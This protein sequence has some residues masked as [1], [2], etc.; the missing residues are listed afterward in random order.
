MNKQE[1]LDNLYKGLKELDDEDML[2]IKDQNKSYEEKRKLL[3]KNG[4]AGIRQKYVLKIAELESEKDGETYNKLTMELI[5]HAVKHNKLV[6]GCDKP[7]TNLLYINDSGGGE[8]SH[9]EM[10]YNHKTYMNRIENDEESELF[11]MLKDDVLEFN[12]CCDK[13]KNGI[14]NLGDICPPKM[15][16]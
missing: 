13:A 10:L 4:N 2:I 8:I 16:E 3:D 6:I 14:I 5:K 12:D 11:L 15:V 9:N 7:T 1:R